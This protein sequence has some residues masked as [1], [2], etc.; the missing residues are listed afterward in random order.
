ME[1]YD[2]V[3]NCIKVRTSMRE[4]AHAISRLDTTLT[5]HLSKLPSTPDRGGRTPPPEPVPPLVDQRSQ[6]QGSH[7]PG[8]VAH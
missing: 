6:T 2:P 4:I 5:Q 1:L 7:A 8:P 3:Q